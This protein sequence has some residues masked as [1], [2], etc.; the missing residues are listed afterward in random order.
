ML[1]VDL[2]ITSASLKLLG[3]L[4]RGTSKTKSLK[5]LIF[6]MKIKM[7]TKIEAFFFLCKDREIFPSFWAILRD[8]A[9]TFHSEPRAQL[10]SLLHKAPL[11]QLHPTPALKTDFLQHHRADTCT[12]HSWNLE[13]MGK[14]ILS[15][16]RT[17][18]STS[19]AEHVAPS[20]Q[21]P[22]DRAAQGWERRR[23][24]TKT[25]KAA[26][27]ESKSVSE[28]WLLDLQ[29]HRQPLAC[30]IQL[31][32]WDTECGDSEVWNEIQ[33]KRSVNCRRIFSLL[34]KCHYYCN[35]IQLKKTKPVLAPN[36]I[37]P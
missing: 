14:L 34:Y 23:R 16:Q 3:F 29:S 37:S 27:W 11:C 6:I 7:R 35:V 15:C 19:R 24:G 18:W 32:L 10:N 20:R 1:M 5:S 13:G 22:S 28:L 17:S 36:V 21:S 26:L 31:L 12:P 33:W 8:P 25:H 2:C 4:P 30:S 9:R